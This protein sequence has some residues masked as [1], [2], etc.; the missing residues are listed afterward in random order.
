MFLK[1]ANQSLQ[2]HM[3]YLYGCRGKIET[4]LAVTTINAGIADIDIEEYQMVYNL[5]QYVSFGFPLKMTDLGI[6]IFSSADTKFTANL[7]K[8]AFDVI[9]YYLMLVAAI[10]IGFLAWVSFKA[11]RSS[12]HSLPREELGDIMIKS[13][14]SVLRQANETR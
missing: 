2:V 4:F 14:G 8:G 10:I 6:F 11:Q 9:S 5:G 13:L 3:K 1:R 7:F 12:D